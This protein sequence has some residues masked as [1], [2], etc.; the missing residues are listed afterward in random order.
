MVK[1]GTLNDHHKMGYLCD[2][3]AYGGAQMKKKTNRAGVGAD[4]PILR[5]RQRICSGRQT[6]DFRTGTGVDGPL[7]WIKTEMCVYRFSLLCNDVAKD[8]AEK[9]T[10][11]FLHFFMC[12]T[13]WIIDPCKRPEAGWTTSV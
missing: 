7:V 13:I 4:W 5:R 11:G 10:A 12:N 2:L 6:K 1:L 3:A 9:S 8:R